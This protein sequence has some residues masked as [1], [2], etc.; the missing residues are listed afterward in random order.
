MWGKKRRLLRQSHSRIE[1]PERS[2]VCNVPTWRTGLLTL[3]ALMLSGLLLPAQVFPPEGWT[4]K[5][6]PLASPDAVVGGEVVVFAGQSPKSFNYY[7]DNNVFSSKVFSSMFETLLNMNSMTLEYEP[8]LAE[9][10]SISADKKTFTFWLDP[11]ARWSDGKPITAEDVKWTYDAIMMPENMTGVHKVSLERLEPPV[12]LGTYK[13]QF[14]AKEVHWQNLGAASGFHILPKHVFAGRDFNKINFEF[15]VVSGPYR[16]GKY[17]EGI[18]ATLEQRHDWWKRNAP[19]SRGSGNF[20]TIKYKFFAERS[21]GFEAFKKGQI[22]MFAVYTAYLWVNQAKGEKFDKNWIVRQKI[23]N[24]HPI[25]FQGFAMNMRRPPFDDVR[26]RK[27]M[28]CLVD[29]RKMNR[30]L[31][32]NQYFLHRSYYEDLYDKEHPCPNT[33]TEFDKEKA[34]KLLAEAGWKVNSQTGFLEK[35]GRRFVI[36][37]LTRAP[38]SEKFLAVFGEALKD[39]GIELVIDKKD[40]AA[41][42]KDMDEFNYEMTWAAWGAGLFKNPESMWASKEADR[43]SGNNIT[44]FKDARVDQLIEKQ[45]AIFDLNQ[46]HQICRE[47]DQIVFEQHPYVLLWNIDYV[48]LLYWNKFG[49]PDTVLSKYGTESTGYWW[50]DEDASAE[51]AHAM[52]TGQA[53]PRKPG[54][55][56]FSEVFRPAAATTAVQARS[57]FAPTKTPASGTLGPEEPGKGGG[58]RNSEK[59]SACTLIAMAPLVAMLAVV[60][61][62]L[63]ALAYVWRMRR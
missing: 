36:K 32:Y 2:F 26:V 19:S 53:L 62:S 30:T 29:R 37:F 59:E 45:K 58:P 40:W 11:D 57:P 12:V 52:A 25:G 60:S 16:L 22:D 54:K 23:V 3:T 42:A 20:Q 6:D 10:W 35:Q 34:R 17:E 5:L 46:R 63:F 15:P 33:L 28:A 7:L 50:L 43:R 61:L 56:V 24:R 41:W 31:M 49:T 39:V 18:Y 44:G 4:D 13:I 27:A 51:L 38:S 9:K 55:V 48:R 14:R 8:H 1:A 21:N 47:V